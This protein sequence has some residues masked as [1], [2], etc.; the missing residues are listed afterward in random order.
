MGREGHMLG[1]AGWSLGC[2][3]DVQGR[4][5]TQSLELGGEVEVMSWVGGRQQEE[6]QSQ[7]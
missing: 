1:A 7:P 4:L 3:G 6:E 2:L 5:W